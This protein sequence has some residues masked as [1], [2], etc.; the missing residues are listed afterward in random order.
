MSPLPPDED[1][2]IPIPGRT[3]RW[4]LVGFVASMLFLGTMIVLLAFGVGFRQ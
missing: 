1:R 3:S 4:A 2:P